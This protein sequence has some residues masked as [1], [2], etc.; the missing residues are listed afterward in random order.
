MIDRDKP[1]A[2]QPSHGSR[3]DRATGRQ[4]AACVVGTQ[5]PSKLPPLW[6]TQRLRAGQLR[7]LRPTLLV[8]AGQLQRAAARSRCGHGPGLVVHLRG[9]R[10]RGRH[11]GTGRPPGRRHPRL[12]PPATSSLPQGRRACAFPGRNIV[13]DAPADSA[14]TRSAARRST[15][16]SCPWPPRRDARP[17]NL[18][19]R[20]RSQA[21]TPGHPGDPAVNDRPALDGLTGQEW[22]VERG[23]RSAPTQQNAERPRRAP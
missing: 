23:L 14:V 1:A 8:P 2:G 11:A 3:A 17:E 19:M 4:G 22:P 16:W 7:Q 5:T 10:R 15:A 18:P 21:R 9:M 20:S 6:R 12:S 13:G